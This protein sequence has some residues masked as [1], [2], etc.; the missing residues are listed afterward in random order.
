MRE[1]RADNYDQDQVDALRKRGV[2]AAAMDSSQTR[3]VWLDTCGK[4]R[5]EE[6]K[7]L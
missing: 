3:D 2:C 6:L 4:L 5:R 1:S 7:L